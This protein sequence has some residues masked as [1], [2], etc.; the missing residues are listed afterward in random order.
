[1]SE[2]RLDFIKIPKPWLNVSGR[3]GP[4]AEPQQAQSYGEAAA[5][6]LIELGWP[7]PATRAT[8]VRSATALAAAGA[9]GAEGLIEGRRHWP[10]EPL[11]EAASPPRNNPIVPQ[12]ACGTGHP[13]SPNWTAAL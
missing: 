12:A 8:R 6:Q 4:E 11:P 7:G 2:G 9:L 10:P 13:G 1:M 3:A 5:T